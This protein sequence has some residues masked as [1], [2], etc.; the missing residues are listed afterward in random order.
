MITGD[1]TAISVVRAF[2][3]L[4]AVDDIFVSYNDNMYFSL[5]KAVIETK[6]I[7]CN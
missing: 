6:F 1:V 5:K 3:F 2:L 4:C 7:C